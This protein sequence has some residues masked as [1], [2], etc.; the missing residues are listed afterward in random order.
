MNPVKMGKF[1]TEL[2][3]E[4]GLSQKD[5]ANHFGINDSSVSKWERG[6][7]APDIYYLGPL[8]E[9]LGVS[10]KELLNGERK[11]PKKT[12]LKHQKKVLEL[13]GVEKKFQKK[14]ILKDISMTIYEGEIVGLVGPN[15]AGKT[16]LLKSILNLYSISKGEVFVMGRNM[17]QNFEEA[18]S[19]IGSLI[20]GPS[21]YS[22]LTG[23]ENIKVVALMNHMKDLGDSKILVEKLKL[24][25]VIH[26]KVKTYSLGMKQR[27]GLVLALMKK[28]KIL[29]LDEPMNGLDPLGI[30]ELRE[31]LKEISQK[32]K[33]SILMSSHIL[34]EME[35]VCDRIIILDNGYIIDD[36]EMEEIQNQEKTLEEEFF[37]LTSGSHHQIGGEV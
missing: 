13:K 11:K 21:S 35:N 9:L 1:I 15:G 2:R 34:S 3:K 23:M 4:K 37:T 26:K 17:Q 7:N 25:H 33:I 10:I 14:V 32:E 29:L 24:N 36:I 19:Q 22:D 31:L 16:T 20:D 30:K 8:S 27:L 28:P 5:I 18:I 12:K 6:I